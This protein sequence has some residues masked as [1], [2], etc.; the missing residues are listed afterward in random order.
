MDFFRKLNLRILDLFRSRWINKYTI[1]AFLF[2]AWLL[3]FDN[4]NLITQW[5]LRKTVNELEQSKEEF[6][7]L[8]V[9]ARL[10][11]EDLEK[12]KERYAR[13]K[14]FMH[15]ADEDVYIIERQ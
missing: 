8:L 3:F 7:N 15:K 12:N 13:E 5:Q 10:E 11:K 2:F 9:S 4:H 6:D 14:Y 1:S